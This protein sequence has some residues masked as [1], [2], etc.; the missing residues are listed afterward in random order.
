[1]FGCGH[2]Q[3]NST[4]DLTSTPS[5][6]QSTLTQTSCCP[7]LWP[8]VQASS[9]EEGEFHACPAAVDASLQEVLGSML[10]QVKGQLQLQQVRS[11][12][13]NFA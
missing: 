10:D 6:L 11:R 9:A 5:H 8:S 1:M 3:R 7:H 13:K 4:S 2:L 12:Y